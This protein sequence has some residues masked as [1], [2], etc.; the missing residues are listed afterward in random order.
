[1]NETYLLHRAEAPLLVSVPHAGTWLPAG[2]ERRLTPEAQSLPDTDWYVDE[3]WSGAAGLRAGLLVA[4]YSRYAVDLNRPPDDQPLYEGA[5]TGLI[6]VETFDG[7]PLYRGGTRPGRADARRRLAAYWQPYHAAL[8]SELERIR[9]RHGFAVLLDAHSIRSRVP[10]LF[11]GR[12]PDLNLGSFDGASA[13][14]GLIRVASDHLR[15]WPECSCVVDGRFKGGFITRHYGRPEQG[16]H[17]LQLEM[18]QAVYMGEDPPRPSPSRM[19]S[20]QRSA[21]SFLAALLAWSPDRG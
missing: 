3:L 17:A 21:N 5:S 2:L 14:A 4:R 13:A 6:P 9:R 16:V 1:M 10:R 18:A 12:L 20:A 19:A 11:D 15:G 7:A 8:A